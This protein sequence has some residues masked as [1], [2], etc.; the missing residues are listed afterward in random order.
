MLKVEVPGAHRVPRHQIDGHSKGRDMNVTNKTRWF[1]AAALAAGLLMMGTASAWYGYPW[2]RPSGAGAM[3]YERQNMMRHHGHAMED[4]S[5]MFG[6]RQAF[7]R[8][9]AVRLAKELEEGFGTKL[10]KNYAP[11]AVVAGSRTAPWTWRNFGTFQG[12]AEAARQSAERLIEALENES[13]DD[14]AASRAIW[15][16][17]GRRAVGPLGFGRDGPIPLQAV[18]EHG[19]LN[20]TC[21]SCHVHFRGV[22][23]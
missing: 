8:E 23:W 17:G 4:L 6:G 15:V 7:N 21:Y 12:Y 10:L 11:G 18:Q 3:T 16:P 2:Y 22:R 14:A 5:R 20:A 1:G 19:R 13:G 9:E